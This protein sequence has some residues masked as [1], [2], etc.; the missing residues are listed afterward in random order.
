MEID[1]NN[2]WK[3]NLFFTKFSL[4]EISYQA[5]NLTTISQRTLTIEFIGF[6][7]NFRWDKSLI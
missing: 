7:L 6:A 2:N 4:V 5:V 3:N 1:F